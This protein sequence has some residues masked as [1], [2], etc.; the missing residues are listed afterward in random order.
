[1]NKTTY[2][3]ILQPISRERSYSFI[4]YDNG[5]AMLTIDSNGTTTVFHFNALDVVKLGEDFNA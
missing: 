5:S 1:M 4:K 2:Q 3:K